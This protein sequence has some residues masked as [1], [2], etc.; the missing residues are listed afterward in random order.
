MSL[1]RR[2]S[3]EIHITTMRDYAKEWRAKVV[4]KKAKASVTLVQKAIEH[5]NNLKD[6]SYESRPTTKNIWKFMMDKC[7]TEENYFPGENI[8]RK[9]TIEVLIAVGEEESWDLYVRDSYDR[10]FPIPWERRN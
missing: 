5:F 1:S 3:L 4:E 6:G 8:M 10:A 9:Y 2:V 7:R